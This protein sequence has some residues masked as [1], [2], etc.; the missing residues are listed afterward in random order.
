MKKQQKEELQSLQ[1]FRKE[2]EATTSI[3]I[4]K[5]ESLYLVLMN[6]GTY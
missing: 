2:H 1:V 3:I 6:E 5:I 4:M